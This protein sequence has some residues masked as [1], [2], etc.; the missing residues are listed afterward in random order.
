MSRTSEFEAAIENGDQNS[1]RGLCEKKSEE[2]EYAICVNLNF[3]SCPYQTH[4][5]TQFASFNSLISQIGRGEGD[6]GLA[7][8]HV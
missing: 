4:P 1:L 2:T 7:E 6:M 8:N 3:H 5:K